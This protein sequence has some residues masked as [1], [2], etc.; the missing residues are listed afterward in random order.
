M[1]EKY[2]SRCK[3]VGTEMVNHA[4]GRDG[5][6]Y[7][8]CRECNTSQARRYRE[9]KK[10]KENIYRAVY[11]SIDKLRYK[12]DA[13]LLVRDAVFSGLLSKPVVC[14]H[15]CIE[16]KLNAHHE[17]YS[18]PLQVLWLCVS[19]HFARHRFLKSNK[20]TV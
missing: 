2:C 6:Q 14:E 8:Y 20:V 7:Y 1:K 3:A 5:T 11:K 16:K 18:K 9:T 13:R 19:C 4:K 17:D 10:G 12:Q 15:C